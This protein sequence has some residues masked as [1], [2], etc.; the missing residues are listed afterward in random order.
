[1]VRKERLKELTSEFGKGIK[2]EKC[3]KCGCMK[4]TLEE[5]RD[6]LAASK[7]REAQAMRK[8]INAWLGQT[9]ESLYT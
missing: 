4:G 5:I 9:E 2:L 3:R 8:K 7:D 6:N 1:M